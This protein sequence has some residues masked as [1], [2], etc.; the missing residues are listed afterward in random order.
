RR[1]EMARSNVSAADAD[2]RVSDI[3]KQR[4][5]YVKRHWNRKWLAHENYHLCLNTSWLS[6]AC[7]AD[8]VTDAARRIGI[9]PKV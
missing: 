4:E 7:A 2:K 6:I 3:N 8:L 5:A 1:Y 9:A